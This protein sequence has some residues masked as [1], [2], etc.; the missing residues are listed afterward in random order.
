MKNSIRYSSEPSAVTMII[1]AAVTLL[2]LG[3]A[4]R[5]SDIAGSVNMTLVGALVSVFGAVALGTAQTGKIV[6]VLSSPAD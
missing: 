1:G 2:G 4:V 6:A 5:G 3:L